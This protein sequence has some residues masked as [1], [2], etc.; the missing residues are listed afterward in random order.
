MKTNAVAEI[1]GL[2]GPV[3]ISE[4]LLQK[5]WLRQDFSDARLRT[6]DGQRLRVRRVGDWNRLEGPDFLGAEVEVGGERLCGDVEVHFYQRDWHAHGHHR[7]PAFGRVIL[8]V[9]LFP[10]GHSEPQARRSDGTRLPTIVLLAHLHDDIEAHAS[11][12]WERGVRDLFDRAAPWL[13]QQP[14]IRSRRLIDLGHRRWRQKLRYA[15]TRLHEGSASEVLHR[16]CLEVMGYRRNRGPMSNLGYRFPLETFVDPRLSPEKL[17][18]NVTGWRHSGIRPANHPVTRLRQ[19]RE[20]VRRSPRWPDAL[21]RDAAALPQDRL[22]LDEVLSGDGVSGRIRWVRAWSKAVDAELFGGCI[23]G[24]RRHTLW[25]DAFWP[26]LAVVHRRDFFGR[27]FLGVPGDYPDALRH[28]LRQTQMLGPRRPP[29]PN[30]YFQG[31]L[32][33]FLEEGY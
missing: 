11:R 7:N 19:Y 17:H 33:H 31:A 15:E 12:E 25:C 8:H 26:L 10:P 29:C 16:A 30:G 20:V 21:L 3:T 28:F 27:W 32:Q 23:G 2:Y 4:L 5:I 9:V 18:K 22:Q 13:A 14:S 1:Q 24:P 6:V